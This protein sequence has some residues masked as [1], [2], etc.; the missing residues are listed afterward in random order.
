[1]KNN[2]Y[3]LQLALLSILAITSLLPAC[4]KVNGDGPVV[5]ETRTA[6]SYSGI[7]YAL[8]GNLHIDSGSGSEI[9]IRAQQN[10]INVIETY[11]ENHTLYIRLR[12]STVIHSHEPIEVYLKTTDPT[13]IQLSGSG[14]IIAGKTI[15]PVELTIASSGSGNIQLEKVNTGKLKARISGSGKIEVLQGSVGTENIQL[16]GSG[17]VLLSGIQADSAFTQ[18]SGSG[19]INLWVKRYL[20]SEISGSG[21]VRYKGAPEVKKRISGSGEVRPW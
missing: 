2:N 6:G 8:Q 7:Q 19:Q 14:N 16:S 10:I 21:I 12:N 15:S 18:T 11:V 20:E 13:M 9:E 5:T 4:T 3:L 1:M 17:Q